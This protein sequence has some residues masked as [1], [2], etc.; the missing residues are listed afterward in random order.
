MNE[1]ANKNGKTV[2]VLAIA[3]IVVSVAAIAL[4][5]YGATM[6]GAEGPPGPEGPEGPPGEPGPNNIVAMG[7]YHS[8]VGLI[9]GY[10]VESVTWNSGWHEYR[11][12]ITDTAYHSWD[13]VTMITTMD[14]I[15]NSYGC[16]S[17]QGDLLAITLYDA[18]GNQLT[19][20]SGAFSFMVLEMPE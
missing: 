14:T 9:E 11:I 7:T 8:S 15:G 16:Y 12:N 18:A 6:E 3:A 4:G 2:T 19:T 13:Y 5:S 10:N 1:E 20:D 17:S